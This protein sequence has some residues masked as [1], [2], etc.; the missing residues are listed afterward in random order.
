MHISQTINILYTIYQDQKTQ[1]QIAITQHE[2]TFM[3]LKN[4]LEFLKAAHGPRHN[5]KKSHNK[6]YF[7]LI[8]GIE[9][10]HGAF[11]LTNANIFSERMSEK[12]SDPELIYIFEDTTSQHQQLISVLLKTD[13]YTP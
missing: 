12:H 11:K 9:L 2:M 7:S 8:L 3:K 5:Q 13:F 4:N 1:L 6:G 10:Q